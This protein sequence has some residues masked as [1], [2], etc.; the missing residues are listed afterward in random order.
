MNLFSFKTTRRKVYFYR[1]FLL[2]AF[3]SAFIFYNL[4]SVSETDISVSEINSN[5]CF[6]ESSQ[7]SIFLSIE[8]D[9]ENL[10]LQN[11]TIEGGIINQIS[12][13]YYFEVLDSNKV[14]LLSGIENIENEFQKV[15]ILI[16]FQIDEFFLNIEIRNPINQNNILDNVYFVQNRSVFQNIESDFVFSP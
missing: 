6:L 4:D 5:K 11:S 14:V 12:N 1:F 13:I 3:S 15:S 7:K 8:C 10:L 2:F 16:P 9:T